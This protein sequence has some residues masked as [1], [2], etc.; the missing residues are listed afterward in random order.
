MHRANARTP[1]KIQ[2]SLPAGFRQQAQKTQGA[3]ING[4]KNHVRQ[5]RE[6]IPVRIIPAIRGHHKTIRWIQPNGANHFGRIL[7][8]PSEQAQRLEGGHD[9]PATDVRGLL[10]IR[11][12]AAYKEIQAPAQGC[13]ERV[14]LRISS[15]RTSPKSAMLSI[16]STRH[17]AVLCKIRTAQ[18]IARQATTPRRVPSAAGSKPRIRNRR[19]E[20][21]RG[22]RLARRRVPPVGKPDP[23]LGRKVINRGQV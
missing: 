6:W 7:P 22:R 5:G 9:F 20:S 8:G 13:R 21:G 19:H 10:I 14:H 3:A 2:R 17:S 16:P 18:K 11:R 15:Q 12:L 1:T 4:R 23:M